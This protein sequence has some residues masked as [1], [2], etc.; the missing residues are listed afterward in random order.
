M[1]Q[2]VY[3]GSL[4]AVVVDVAGRATEAKRGEPFEVPDW[5]ADEITKQKT[6]RK[7][8]PK[9]AAPAAPKRVAKKDEAE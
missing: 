6:Y 8:E 2:I 9:P 5:F 3:V 1:S 7:V 4:P